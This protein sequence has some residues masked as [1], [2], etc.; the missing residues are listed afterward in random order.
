GDR[1]GR[2]ATLLAGLAIF[3]VSSVIA[4]LTDSI[5]MLIVMRAAMGIGAAI[6]TPIV[7]AMI[8]IM[9]D[10]EERPRAVGA[11]TA[12]TSVG[13]PLGPIVGGYLL[14]RFAWSSIFWVNVPVAAIAFIAAVVLIDESRDPSARRLDVP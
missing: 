5:T 12:A 8:P 4:A 6:I 14:D 9:F 10:D 2:K 13:L 7:M 3:L 11:L 1:I